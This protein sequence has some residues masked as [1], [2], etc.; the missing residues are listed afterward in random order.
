MHRKVMTAIGKCPRMDAS[1]RFVA[2]RSALLW[3]IW[4]EKC[5]EK[6]WWS[7]LDFVAAFSQGCLKKK[8]R[9]N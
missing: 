5:V 1:G 7:E 2:G 9:K 6:L 3:R 4:R 8:E